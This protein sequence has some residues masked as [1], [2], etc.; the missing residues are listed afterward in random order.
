MST[1]AKLGY[2]FSVVALMAVLMQASPR[3]TFLT[4]AR[5]TVPLLVSG[6][7]GP[8]PAVS[9]QPAFPVANSDWT[10]HYVP[11][12]KALDWS[13]LNLGGNK[14][15][16][17]TSTAQ[18]LLEQDPTKALA[19]AGESVSAAKGSPV[20]LSVLL[21]AQMKGL[22]FFN[23]DNLKPES[24]QPLEATAA[25]GRA[26]VPDNPF[27]DLFAVAA[28]VTRKQPAEALTVLR[29]ASTKT[30]YNDY[31]KELMGALVELAESRGV[32]PLQAR[33]AAREQVALRAYPRLLRQVYVS[34][35]RSIT[36]LPTPQQRCQARLVMLGLAQRMRDSATVPTAMMG[37]VG[38][39][40]VAGL[41][42]DA[43]S[44]WGLVRFLRELDQSGM[45]V[46]N[47]MVQRQLGI[48]GYLR[49][50]LGAPEQ[51]HPRWQEPLLRLGYLWFRAAAVVAAILLL[52]VLSL[53][54][55]ALTPL[56]RGSRPG[57]GVV[58]TV[59][60]LALGLLWS[61]WV[62]AIPSGP[63]ALGGAEVSPGLFRQL[64]LALPLVALVI[65]CQGLKKGPT[66]WQGLASTMQSALPW[67]LCVS[68]LAFMVAVPRL[69][70]A[71]RESQV[72]VQRLT[73]KGDL[74]ADVTK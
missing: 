56:T 72:A 68:L 35:S 64:A 28:L 9:P 39:E 73:S 5:E 49:G 42:E 70:S 48:A 27:F 74:P 20:S 6:S 62:L 10:F 65:G 14:P 47:R 40:M 17:V 21:E 23:L 16:W 19:L 41:Q 45:R 12:L 11:Y 50:R 13:G 67:T 43:P 15:T 59:A 18:S 55:L 4:E 30:A 44:G 46:Q 33:L 37:I 24:M 31:S 1:T 69:E 58:A 57:A 3:Q 22:G 61:A 38:A 2:L 7:P 60:A 25:R 63:V 32:R 71:K 36:Q 26:A 54:S 53:L 51:E 34:L 52:A 66:R 29:A 8:D